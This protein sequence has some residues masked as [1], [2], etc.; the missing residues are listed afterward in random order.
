[1]AAG[2]VPYT[3]ILDNSLQSLININKG[4][5]AFISSVYILIFFCFL[6]SRLEEE[7]IVCFN[8]N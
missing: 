6:F 1:M 2:Y 4:T 7:T 8:F 5:I 3:I